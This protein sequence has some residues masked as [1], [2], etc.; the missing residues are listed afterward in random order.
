MMM[1]GMTMAMIMI[2][3]IWRDNTPDP[4]NQ[5]N[6]QEMIRWLRH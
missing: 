2:M 6:F 4:V 3:M 1:T 5:A